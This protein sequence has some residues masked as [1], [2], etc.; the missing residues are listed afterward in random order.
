V[1]ATA[2]KPQADVIGLK[3]LAAVAASVKIPVAAIGGITLETVRPVLAAGARYC[4]VISGIN[5]APDP[6]LALRRFLAQ[7][8]ALPADP[9][10]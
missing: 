4:A 1:F 6:A 9:Q 3:G 7:A 2:T 10:A 8:A 5:D